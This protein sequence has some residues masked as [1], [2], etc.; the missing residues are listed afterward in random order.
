MQQSYIWVCC[1]IQLVQPKRAHIHCAACTSGLACVRDCFLLR[2]FCE[3]VCGLLCRVLCLT[4][5]SEMGITWIKSRINSEVHLDKCWCCTILLPHFLRDK[6]SHQSKTG[7]CP[8]S[9][10][11]RSLCTGSTNPR[12]TRRPHLQIVVNTLLDISHWNL[13]SK[14]TPHQTTN[15]LFQKTVRKMEK[16]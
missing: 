16:N 5:D 4:N 14:M 1:A 10:F 13:R 11:H 2:G 7:I 12:Q 8:T 15:Q 6:L 3:S 9:P